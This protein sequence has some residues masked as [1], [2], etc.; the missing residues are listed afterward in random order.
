MMVSTGS[1]A[2]WGCLAGPGILWGCQVPGPSLTEP[3]SPL[4]LT[5]LHVAVNTE[6]EEAVLLLLERGAD[7]DAVVSEGAGPGSAAH[8]GRGCVGERLRGNAGRQL[9]GQ[10]SERPKGL[11]S[12]PQDIKSGR[13][14]LIHAVENNSLSM[15]QLLLQVGGPCPRAS[16]PLFPFPIQLRPF[17]PGLALAALRLCPPGCELFL[18][19]CYSSVAPERP[20]PCPARA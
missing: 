9:S 7:I 2:G 20:R 10:S 4:G 6:C 16:P 12:P 5:A 14:P 13:S 19:P 1:G 18:G 15:V 3:P 8:R 17:L 11:P